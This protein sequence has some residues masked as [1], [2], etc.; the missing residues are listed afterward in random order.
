MAWIAS[1]DGLVAAGYTTDNKAVQ[2]ALENILKL[3]QEDGSWPNR[4]E[5]RVVPTLISLGLIA[6]KQASQTIATLEGTQ[7]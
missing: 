6:P 5:L 2:L 1:L 3:Q 7:S 4:Y